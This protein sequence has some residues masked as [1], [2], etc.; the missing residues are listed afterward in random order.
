MAT[1]YEV[2][3]VHRGLDDF[4][5]AVRQAVRAAA[6]AVLLQPDLITFKDD[7]SGSSP[8]D[9]TIVAYLASE[10]G[11]SDA[12]VGVLM[13]DALAG[14]IPVLPL[15]RKGDPGS[16]SEKLPDSI[17]RINAID[18]DERGAESVNAILVMLG[19]TECRLPR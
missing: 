1:N 18:W 3:L 16:V 14:Q 8:D 5:E 19:L 17:K 2:V 9:H 12:E 13:A 7:L 4:A 6:E 11:G 10:A 15:A